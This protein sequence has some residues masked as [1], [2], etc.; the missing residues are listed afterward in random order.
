MT[1]KI[2]ID[3]SGVVRAE[4]VI[5]RSF[6]NIIR[7]AKDLDNQLKSVDG[8]LRRF[9][10]LNTF[11]VGPIVRGLASIRDEIVDLNVDLRTEIGLLQDLVRNLNRVGDGSNNASSGMNA[12]SVTV[13]SLAATAISKLLGL[14][15][16]LITI[17]PKT[18]DEWTKVTN[19]I[20]VF[21]S[22][23]ENLRQTQESLVDIAIKTRTNLVAQSKLYNRLK[24]VSKNLSLSQKDIL[25][26]VTN[27]GRAISITA[28]STQEARGALIQ[29]SQALSQ[30]TVRAEEMNSIMEGTP[31]IAQAVADAL[32]I[33]ATEVRQLVLE[34]K[35]A[36]ETFALALESQTIELEEQFNQLKYTFTSGLETLKTGFVEFVGTLNETT[37][38][39]ENVGGYLEKA[40]KYLSHTARG[41]K[42]LNLDALQKSIEE[43]LSILQRGNFVEIKTKLILDSTDLS[44][45]IQTRLDFI[46]KD[47]DVQQQKLRTG[48]SFSKRE[49]NKLIE[50]RQKLLDLLSQ[51]QIIQNSLL[52]YEKDIKKEKEDKLALDAKKAQ[53][54]L[55]N[56]KKRKEELR[57]QQEQTRRNKELAPLRKQLRQ[58]IDLMV[59]AQSLLNKEMRK[60]IPITEERAALF[61]KLRTYIETGKTSLEKFEKLFPKFRTGARDA[62]DDITDQLKDL[63]KEIKNSNNTFGHYLNILKE[64]NKAIS[65]GKSN[66]DAYNKGLEIS[67]KLFRDLTSVEQQELNVLYAKR[68]ELKKQQKIIQNINSNVIAYQ[69]TISTLNTLLLE[70]K[71]SEPQY[72]VQKS[73]TPLVSAVQD[74][75]FQLNP[76]S[77]FGD[78]ER[79]LEEQRTLYNERAVIL[80]EALNTELI[81]KDEFRTLDLE[82]EKQY[83][84]AI[85]DA[86]IAKNSIVL[87][88]ASSLF[89]SLASIS[90]GFVGEESG[91][92]KKLFAVSK[93]FAIADTSIQ[94]ADA[95]AKALA[96]GPFPANL[97]AFAEVAALGS[98]LISQISSA[99]FAGAFQNGG[100]FRVGGSGGPDSQLVTLKASPSETVSVRTPSQQKRYESS[101]TTEQKQPDINLKV[102][103]ILD[104]S[105][106]GEYLQSSQ[107][108]KAFVNIIQRNSSVIRNILGNR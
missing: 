22:E 41:L 79:E 9:G 104:P 32:G 31:R 35:L 23:S 49:L 95:T 78:I 56:L 55:E 81:T 64:E 47:I 76:V 45:Q 28:T 97:V 37:D 7:S 25:Q 26:I 21:A 13:G 10:N 46:N 63:D 4:R 73:K 1:L 51:E 44:K 48:F 77:G 30:G 42:E 2:D 72:E 15:K 96:S 80:T 20:K 106:V 65:E 68:E 16:D 86:N 8:R 107:G 67:K 90:A 11:N 52:Q 19:N 5:D 94:I 91:T 108:E 14:L 93:A 43:R 3:T 27:V 105:L 84:Q 38:I 18:A 99:N 17:L 36:S 29:L 70:D 6:K 89:G 102:A 69:R 58:D 66:K 50:E 85:I 103:N 34:G 71:I 82:R 39:S 59:K 61:S 33:Q 83:N 53:Q 88:N 74:V 87:N 40:G 98:T 75:K 12:F 24:I 54:D 62:V 100:E 60:D 57:L 92:Y 101:K